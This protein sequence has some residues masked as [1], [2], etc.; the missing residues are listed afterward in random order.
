MPHASS[1]GGDDMRTVNSVTG[2]AAEAAGQASDMTHSGG[3]GSGGQVG[4]EAAGGTWME[5]P[6]APLASTVPPASAP[7]GPGGTWMERAD[8]AATPSRPGLDE[9]VAA[10][11]VDGMTLA[12]SYPGERS[13]S[14]AGE[15]L[16]PIEPHDAPAEGRSMDLPGADRDETLA[17]VVLGDEA[18]RS[19]ADLGGQ[20]AAE[21]GLSD[22]GDQEPGE[23]GPGDAGDDE[24]LGEAPDREDVMGDTPPGATNYVEAAAAVEGS[25]AAE[26]ESPGDEAGRSLPDDPDAEMG[27]RPAIQGGREHE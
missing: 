17:D 7:E 13:A 23:V 22:E 5:E 2:Q 11:P 26:A 4:T 19:T 15:P 20:P 8:E 25:D 24:A 16:E 21:V 14:D 9:A 10:E 12:A 1:I 27:D 18:H 6:D 3:P